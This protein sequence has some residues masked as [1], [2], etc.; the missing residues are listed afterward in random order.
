[1]AHVIG[2]AKEAPK[3]RKNK[4]LEKISGYT[5]LL[6]ILFIVFILGG[7]VY[8]IIETPAAVLQTSTGAYTSINPYAG[9]QTINESIVSMFLYGLC[10]VGLFLVGRSTQV[11][12]D[13]SKAN[14]YLMS[15]L[16]SL[17][18]GFAFAYLIVFFIK[19]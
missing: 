15:G 5:G 12:Y 17:M 18:V 3:I 11:L 16:S 7:G 4:Q 2:K 13:K 9:E 1:M 10:I 14:L 19:R 8:D 6:M